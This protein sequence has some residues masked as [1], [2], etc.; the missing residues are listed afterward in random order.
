MVEEALTAVAA[1]GGTAVVQAAGTEAWAGLRQAAAR[2]FGRGDARRERTELERLDR[3]AAELTG[4]GADEQVRV[5]QVAVWQTRFEAALEALDEAEQAAAVNGLRALL[6][7]H[8]P[9]PGMSADR[10]GVAAGGNVTIRATHGSAAA[11]RMGNVTLGNPPAS[12]AE[13]G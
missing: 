7:E 2:W 8:A 4:D 10:G 5:R 12:G 9:A 6:D 11:I 13:Q 1:A 3:S